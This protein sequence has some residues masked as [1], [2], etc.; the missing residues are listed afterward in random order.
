MEVQMSLLM[1]AMSAPPSS[2]TF[3]AAYVAFVDDWDPKSRLIEY[4]ERTFRT[5]A[6]DGDGKEWD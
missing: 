3:F 4:N 5:E 1:S 2:G 6:V